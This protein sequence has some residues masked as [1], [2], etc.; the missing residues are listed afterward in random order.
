MNNVRWV[1][2]AID[3][4]R[5]DLIPLIKFLR[6]L[7]RAI[8][9]ESCSLKVGKQWAEQIRDTDGQAFLYLP[10]QL[11]L[12]AQCYG[13]S[14]GLKIDPVSPE[15]ESAIELLDTMRQGV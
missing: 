7:T 1:Y 9:G 2:A 8:E 3:I 11:F 5:C 14:I 12:M 6:A 15:V 13:H 10:E 4:H